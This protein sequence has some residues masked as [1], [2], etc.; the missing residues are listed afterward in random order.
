MLTDVN[1]HNRL[2]VLERALAQLLVVIVVVMRSLPEQ[3]QAVQVVQ[4]LYVPGITASVLWTDS[5]LVLC[6]PGLFCVR[7]WNSDGAV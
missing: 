1:L 7:F 6:D 5:D 4:A 3:V 2:V